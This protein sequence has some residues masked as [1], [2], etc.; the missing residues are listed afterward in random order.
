MGDHKH[1][2]V[3][4]EIIEGQLGAMTKELLGGGRGLADVLG[5]DLVA[6][7]I[8]DGIGET[9]REAYA[10]GADRVYAMDIP[11]AY[12]ANLYA[13]GLANILE[14]EQPRYF[15]FGHDDQGADLGPALAFKLNVAAATD[16]VE[17]SVEEGTKR[18]LVTKPVYGALVMAK[19]STDDLPQIVTVRPKSMIAPDPVDRTGEVRSLDAGSTALNG[20]VKVL[21]KIVEESEGIKLEDAELIVSGGRGIGDAEG[22]KKLAEVAREL[23]GAMGAS[24]VACDNEWV[25]ATI[26]V[27]IT[28]KIVA[29]RIYIAVGISGASQHMSGCSR[30]KTIIAI[31]KDPRAAIF[32]Q[33]QYGVVGDWKIV[34]PVL[35]D[36]LKALD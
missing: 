36:K 23:K 14:H 18:L 15:L 19:F 13:G 20:R 4:G 34:L 10:F 3:Y 33:A 9:A 30:S 35:M 32:K 26:Q 24:R 22:F 8:G 5:E 12:E 28:G 1:I 2:V 16:C 25:P 7:F 31:N 17:L 29:P 27:G 21:E 11:G 6:V